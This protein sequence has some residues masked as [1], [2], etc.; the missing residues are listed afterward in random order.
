MKLL[1]WNLYKKNNDRH[2]ADLILENQID[3]AIFAEYENTDFQ[4]VLKKLGSDYKRA[5]GKYVDDRVVLICKKKYIVS[6]RRPQDRY[7]LYSVEYDEY[8]YL[9]AGIHLQSRLH[10]KTEDRLD[11]IHDLV[12]DIE[13]QERLLKH[14]NTIVIGDFNASPFDK[15]LILKTG[16]NAVLYK[17]LIR[18]NESVEYRKKRY[19]R[20]YNPMLQIYSENLR[21]YGSYY[22]SSE[23][24]SLYW[25]SFDQVIVRKSLMDNLKKVHYCKQIKNKSLM[26]SVMP[27][28]SISDHLP[29]IVTFEGEM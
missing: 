15:E 21:D 22:Y 27:N 4:S 28:L 14:S 17:E 2:I 19:K 8:K 20:F 6:V 29:L 3:V 13:Q 23:I 16:F 10:S 9:V 18:K 26:K 12:E 1:F 25:Y 24:D 11:T 7:L 5:E